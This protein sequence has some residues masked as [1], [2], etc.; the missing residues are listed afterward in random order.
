MASTKLAESYA[1]SAVVL[2][3]ACAFFSLGAGFLLGVLAGASWIRM[4]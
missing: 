4:G 1:E 3:L 2:V